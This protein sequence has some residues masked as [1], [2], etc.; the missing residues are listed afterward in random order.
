MR[1]RLLFD[2][3]YL[4]PLLGIGIKNIGSYDRYIGDILEEYLVYY[5]PVSLIESK[6]LLINLRKKLSYRELER[7]LTRFRMG[8]NYILE[9]GKLHQ[10]NFTNTMMEGE[11]D[12]L[13]S[14]GY[15]D[16]FDLLIFATSYIE[17][18]TLVTEDKTLH[19]IP[20][21]ISKYKDMDILNWKELT[22][23]IEKT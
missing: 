1:N 20:K 23:Q 13:I 21:K 22:D 18:I 11:V 17:K 6:W 5:H 9:S 12:H 4:L 10:L 16:Y 2:T 15:T 3:T 8:M 19:E 14:Q 7:A